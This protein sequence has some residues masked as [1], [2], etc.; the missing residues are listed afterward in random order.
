V[1]APLA[2]DPM[3]AG[4]AAAGG[5][6]PPD[7]LG[8]GGSYRVARLLESLRHLEDAGGGGCGAPPASPRALACDGGGDC[9][10]SCISISPSDSASCC[11][12]RAGSGGCGGGG[13]GAPPGRGG[14]GRRGVFVGNLPGCATERALVGLFGQC[15]PIDRLWIARDPKNQL[16]LGY[17]E[18]PLELR[19]GL[20]AAR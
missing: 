12:L 20:S 18:P 15:G 14:R 1:G 2:R 13:G 4:D 5:P 7:A 9:G 3:P 10:G 6:P 8:C 16:S 11:L 19:W 17:G